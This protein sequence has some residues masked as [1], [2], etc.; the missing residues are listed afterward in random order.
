MSVLKGDL[1][2]ITRV[3]REMVEDGM[4]QGVRYMEVGTNCDLI[5]KKV[6]FSFSKNF[7]LISFSTKKVGIDPRKFLAE[8]LSANDIVTA[9]LR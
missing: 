8:G 7:I 5:F 1:E 9:A 6:T 2:S 3:A 4:E